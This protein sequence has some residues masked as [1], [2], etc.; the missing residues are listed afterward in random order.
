MSTRLAVYFC[1]CAHGGDLE[2]YQSDLISA[3]AKV[4]DSRINY[5]EEVARVEVEVANTDEFLA[6]FKET[7]S[8]EFATI[9]KIVPRS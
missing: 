1:E 3:G 4:G 8:Y 9:R 7:D 2:A 6:K 5:E